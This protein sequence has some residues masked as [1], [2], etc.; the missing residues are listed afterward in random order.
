MRKSGD[1]YSLS[2]TASVVVGRIA[3]VE[4][5]SGQVWRYLTPP[6]NFVVVNVH[7]M[8]REICEAKRI[9]M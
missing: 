1:G 7:E 8:G 3:E 4:G 2:L 6:W 5:S 9:A